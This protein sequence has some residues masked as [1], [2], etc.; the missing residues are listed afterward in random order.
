MSGAGRG[1]GGESKAGKSCS[2]LRSEIGRVE[3]QERGDRNIGVQLG[4]QP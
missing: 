1:S 3:A 4:D 2:T